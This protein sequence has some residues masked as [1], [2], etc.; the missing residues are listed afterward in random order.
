MAAQFQHSQVIDRPI[1]KVFHFMVNEHVR[2]HPRW[3]PDIELWLEAERP[4]EVGTVIRRRNRR[5]GKPVEGTMQV[6]EYDHNRAFGMLIHDGPIKMNGRITFEPTG[7]DSTIVTTYFELPD[8]DESMDKTFLMRR[9]EE[10]G[11]VRKK[12]IESEIK[13]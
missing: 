7:D 5:S 3:D 12:L 8:M 11:K 10:S 4:I 13:E 1:D 6:V 9:L 2:N